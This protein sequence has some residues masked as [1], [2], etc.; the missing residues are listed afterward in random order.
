[1][2][3]VLYLLTCLLPLVG[4]AQEEREPTTLFDKSSSMDFF[5]GYSFDFMSVDGDMGRSRVWSIGTMVGKHVMIG[6]YTSKLKSSNTAAFSRPPGAP[7]TDFS[8]ELQQGGVLLGVFTNTDRMFH[9]GLSSQLGWG[10]AV[11]RSESGGERL[12]D[13]IFSA[14]PR[15]ELRVNLVQG[16]R[17][18]TFVGYQILEGYTAPDSGS[19]NSPTAGIGLMLGVF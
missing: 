8:L 1:M 13:N 14:M 17:L 5:L 16:L 15:A 11:W 3:Q 12:R 6:G 2:K 10:R 7:P 18:Q 4:W 9:L 19:M